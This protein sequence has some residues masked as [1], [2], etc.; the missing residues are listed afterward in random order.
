MTGLN[1]FFEAEPE[2]EYVDV[3]DVMDDCEDID[4]DLFGEF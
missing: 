2:E 4:D 1:E 3:M